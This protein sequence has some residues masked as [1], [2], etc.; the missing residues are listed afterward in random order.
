MNKENK[1]IYMIGIGGISMSGIAEILKSW[2]YEVSGSDKVESS[3]TKYLEEHG[4]NVYI[5]QKKENITKDIDLVVYTAAIKE[6]NPE[7]IAAKNYRY[8]WYSWKNN[9]H[10]YG[11]KCISRSKS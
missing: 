7:L 10:K 4:I 1:H 6:D 11:F 2:H 3:Q 8:C 5:G 9:Y